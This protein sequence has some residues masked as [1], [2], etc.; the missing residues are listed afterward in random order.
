MLDATFYIRGKKLGKM[1]VRFVSKEYNPKIDR[2]NIDAALCCLT[3]YE[4]VYKIHPAR[5]AGSVGDSGSHAPS[6]GV[7]SV[8]D[9]K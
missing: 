2:L 8:E 3:K 7:W 6:P 5:N 1:E 9:R 4:G